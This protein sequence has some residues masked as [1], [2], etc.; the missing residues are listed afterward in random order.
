MPSYPR[1]PICPVE[2]TV[3]RSAMVPLLA[4]LLAVALPRGVASAASFPGRDGN[5]AVEIGSGP[6]HDKVLVLDTQTGG[7]T[8]FPFAPPFEEDYAATFPAWSPDGSRLAISLQSE[9]S[10][11]TVSQDIVVGDPDGENLVDVTAAAGDQ[12]QP[13]WSPDATRLVYVSVDATTGVSN[14]SVAA[15][16]GSAVQTLT[17]D[18]G[19]DQFPVWSP[20]G[21]KIAFWSDRDAEP[22]GSVGAVYTMGPDG[23]N[24]IR[25]SD[26]DVLAPV[27]SRPPFAWSA[28]GR[29]LT[30]AQGAA[31]LAEVF[32]ANVDGSGLANVTN[33]PSD[34]IGPIWSTDGSTI[35]FASNRENDPSRYDVYLMRPDGTRVNQVTDLPIRT[36]PVAW[37][38]SDPPRQHAG[39]L[40]Q[41]AALGEPRRVRGH[42]AGDERRP[43]RCRQRAAAV[44]GEG[45]GRRRS[46]PRHL[47]QRPHL[48]AG[49]GRRD[50]GRGRERH[51]RGRPG[52]RPDARGTG[53][54]RDG[55]CGG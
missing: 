38:P 23:S 36:E 13:A 15:A 47:G 4:S 51:H 48:R 1:A 24:P 46:P 22:F 8:Y 53:Q 17:D 3:R 16:D 50:L 12:S 43:E 20:N 6:G 10:F 39:L 2:A 9:L 52:E 33:D 49:G 21:S 31:G 18:V 54:R 34:D 41:P 44:H 42:A 7:S 5:I 19:S 35:A 55:R 29:Q 45:N 32:V 11:P 26:V 27:S 30:F 37:S 40:Q 14:I 28:D 25:V